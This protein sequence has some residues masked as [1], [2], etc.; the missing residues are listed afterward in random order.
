MGLVESL[1][2]KEIAVRIGRDASIVS[3]EVN[4]HGDR[5]GYRAV[6]A[7]GAA[8][9]ARARPKPLAV[10]RNPVL[11]S[12]VVGLLRAGWS[13]ASIAGR[14]ARDEPVRDAGKVSHEAVCQWVYAQPVATLRQEL[15]S[16]RTGRTGRRG[17]RP[18]P[19]IREPRHLDERP[20]EADDRAVPGHWEGDSVIGKGG[21]SAVATLV[22]RTS[23]FL[24]LVPLR[25]RD[26]LTVTDAIIAAEINDRPRKIHNWK[27]P[28]EV[29][30]ELLEADASTA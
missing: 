6:A 10:D 17:P 18:A 12:R 1:R 30:T 23:R 19:R 21:R 5:D 25:G 27:K 13:P 26:S 9:T 14:L 20:A 22:E 11:R 15:I 7:D 29:F 4:R 16:L 24:V 28:G 3:R 2:Y 8:G